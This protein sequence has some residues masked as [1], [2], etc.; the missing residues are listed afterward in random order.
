[1]ERLQ[2]VIASSGICSRRK[3]EQLIIDGKVKVNGKTITTL[4]TKV[5]EDDAIMVNNKKINIENKVYYILNKPRN[6]IS[7]VSDEHNRLIITDLIKEKRR[8]F[9]VGRLDYDTT[10]LII[11]TNDGEL[12]NILMHPSNEVE[13][14]YVAKVEGKISMDVLFK[15]KNG[16][17]IDGTMVFPTLVKIK[18]YNKDTNTSII[19]ISLIE[20]QNHVVKKIFNNVGHQVIKLKR[21]TYG[22]LNLGTLKSG[23][24]RKLT[25]SEVKELYEYKK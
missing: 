2:K 16:I 25:N 13:K 8:I 19:K 1:M 10:G 14:T 9:P 18:S 17:E 7:S 20:G 4:G 12:S 21:E 15:I 11:L 5:N 23:D 22:F 3:A 24:Y 6:V